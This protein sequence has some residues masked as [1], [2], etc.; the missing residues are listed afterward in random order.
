MSLTG[1]R[2]AL[3]CAPSVSFEDYGTALHTAF[4]VMIALFHRAKT[5]EGQIVDGSLLATGV[6]F[7]QAFLAER[8]V[9]GNQARG[10]RQCRLLF[11]ARRRLSH[12]RRMDHGADHRRRYVRAMG[13]HGG[14]RRAGW[15]IRDSPTIC[16]ARTIAT[17]I[18]DGDERVD[19]GADRRPRRSRSWKRRAFPRGRCMSS[20]RCWTIRR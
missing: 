11:G 3:R 6:T 8:S 16:R 15:A 10:T 19:R 12:Q 17:L 18:A 5:G 4:G 1:F 2:R 14:P 9:R 13:A 7:M 20:I